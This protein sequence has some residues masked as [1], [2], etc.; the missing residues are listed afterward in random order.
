MLAV[1]LLSL[2]S[3]QHCLKGWSFASAR[4]TG[5]M[6]RSG[7]FLAKRGSDGVTSYFLIFCYLMQSD[8]FGVKSFIYVYMIRKLLDQC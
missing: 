5:Y 6:K 8:T 2:V 3:L 7:L 4:R 1:S